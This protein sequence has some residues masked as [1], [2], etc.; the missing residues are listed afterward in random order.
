MSRVDYPITATGLLAACLLLSLTVIGCEQ[1]DMA[2]SPM[3]GASTVRVEV[4][5]V[6]ELDLTEDVVMAGSVEGFET[7]DLYAKVGGY[8]DKIFVDIGD[9]FTVDQVLATLKVPELDQKLTQKTARKTLAEAGRRRAVAAV[10]EAGSQVA[11]AT[12]IRVSAVATWREKKAL[13]QKASADFDRL[14]KLGNS[15]RRELIE[16]AQYALA[17]ATAAVETAR[18]QVTAAGAMVEAATAHQA[19][20]KED[21]SIADAGVDVAEAELA[22]INTMIS[23]ATIRAPF[24]GAVLERMVDKGDFVQSAEGNSAARPLL[25]VAS[26]DKVRVRLDVPMSRVA[27]LDLEDTAVL[28]RVIAVPGKSFHGTVSRFSAGLNPVSRMM[29]VE[30][31]LDPEGVLR[32]GYY[33]YMTITLHTHKDT[34]VVPSSALLV[35]GDEKYVFVVKDGVATRRVVTTKYQDG[36]V[37]GIA[38]GLN[39]G[40][41]VVRSGG[42]QLSDGQKVDAKDAMWI[43]KG[44]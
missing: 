8:L 21:E 12:A 40:E 18:A 2:S 25:R 9:T 23:Y 4:I 16:S 20:V 27:L 44:S 7:V 43:P 41:R 36:E 28:D 14:S 38:S 13:E 30:V 31:D 33:G 26:V 39:K 19:T 42:G 22:Y 37:V 32:P 5:S 10:K 3:G 11:S 6:P 29:R 17:A 34:P 1:T 35:S 15:V 24:G